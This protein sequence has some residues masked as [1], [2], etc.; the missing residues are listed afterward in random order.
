[1]VQSREIFP[2]LRQGTGTKN[3]YYSI[4]APTASKKGVVAAI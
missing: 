2:G 4:N 3:L 1:M